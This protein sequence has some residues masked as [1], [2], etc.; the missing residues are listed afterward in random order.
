MTSARA[1]TAAAP[2]SRPPEKTSPRI[3][4][5]AKRGVALSS[6]A[7]VLTIAAPF[8]AIWFVYRTLKKWL[9]IA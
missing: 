1:E 8:L 4:V 2:R 6:D 5:V 7:V 3:L 9:G